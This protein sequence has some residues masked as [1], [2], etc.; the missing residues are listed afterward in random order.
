M[1]APIGPT[2]PLAIQNCLKIEPF[3]ILLSIDIIITVRR[4]FNETTMSIDKRS[5]LTL[6]LIVRSREV[7]R[8]EIS[9]VQ[10]AEWS[11]AV[12]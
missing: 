2:E 6:N 8:Y 3:G 4:L 11:K 9:L 5:E 12:I 7:I 1:L 10:L